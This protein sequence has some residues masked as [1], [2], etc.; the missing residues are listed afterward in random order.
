MA[1]PTV[2][3]DARR[4]TLPLTSAPRF[5]AR[6]AAHEQ[7]G[8]AYLA[9]GVDALPGFDFISNTSLWARDPLNP[10]L[11]TDLNATFQASDP[12]V[13][14]D[15]EQGVWIMIYFGNGDGTGGGANIYAAFSDDL[16]SWEKAAEPLYR[17]GGHPKGFDADHAHKVWLTSDGNGTLYMYY[18]GVFAG[19]R[20]IL[21]LT[22]NPITA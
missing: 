4:D 1:A 17:H 20:G 9:G 14:F 2:R 22:S 12:K 7:S 3:R 10:L 6:P 13:Y 15:A 11:P 21:L 8:A 16:R 5:F 19:G 18:T